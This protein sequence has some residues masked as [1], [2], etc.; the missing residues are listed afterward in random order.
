MDKGKEYRERLRTVP[1][2][3]SCESDKET[4]PAWFHTVN[5][6]RRV[7]CE[8]LLWQ[9]KQQDEQQQCMKEIAVLEWRQELS[10]DVVC[11]HT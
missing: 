11:F 2:T 5:G 8:S 6:S 1:C 7:A 3:A 4:F 9:L 10:L